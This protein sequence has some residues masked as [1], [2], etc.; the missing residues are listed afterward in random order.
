[1][2]FVAVTRL[3]IRAFRFLPAFY[4]DAARSGRQARRAP[5]NLAVDILRDAH[6]TFWTQTLWTDEQAA[7]SY[8]TSRPH[9]DA[10]PRLAR[11]CDEASV[12]H[13]HQDGTGRPGWAEAGRRMQQDGRPSR[14]TEPTD[15]H[16]RHEIAAPRISRWRMLRLR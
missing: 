8:T 16:R 5:G 13:W 7:R 6:R 11:W 15:A 10:M 1:M 4:L 12:V 14:V 2:P 9:R 3:R